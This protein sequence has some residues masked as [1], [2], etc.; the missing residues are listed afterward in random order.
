MSLNF[1]FQI[2]THSL[3]EFLA[4]WSERYIIKSEEKYTD[5]I[6]KPLTIQSRHDL[7]EWKNGSKIADHKLRSIEQNYP[8]QFLGNRESRYLNHQMGGGAIWNIFYSHCLD[9]ENWP[10]FDQHT[11]RA[12]RFLVGGVIQEIGTT[13][14]RKYQ[15][16][17]QEYLPFLARLKQEDSRRTDKALFAFGQYLKMAGKYA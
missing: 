16:Y 9:P 10:I 5:N 14:R 12:M 6:G 8:L 13:D 17:L 11:Y 15:N 1:T 7:F 2:E 3:D 4:H